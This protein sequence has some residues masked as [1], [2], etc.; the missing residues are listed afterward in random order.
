[1]NE[2]GELSSLQLTENHRRVPF[3]GQAISLLCGKRLRRIHENCA[4]SEMPLQHAHDGRVARRFV[5]PGPTMQS[6]ALRRFYT[7]LKTQLHCADKRWARVLTISLVLRP[8][9]DHD[10]GRS[11]ALWKSFLV[12]AN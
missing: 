7:E 8:P 4:R 5:H 6:P 9:C 1:M 12:G 11:F 2:H 3:L 10:S